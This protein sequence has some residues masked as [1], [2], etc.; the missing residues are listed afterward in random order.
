MTQF[1]RRQ[2]MLGTGAALVLPRAAMARTWD[3]I[4][5]KSGRAGTVDSVAKALAVAKA[6][7]GRCR[8]KVERGLYREKLRIDVPDAELQGVGPD[9]IISFGAAAGLLNPNGKKWGTGGSATLTVTAPGVILSRM[10]IRNDFDYLSDRITGASG[11]AQ[12][13]ALSLARGHDRSMVRDCVIEGYQDSLYVQEGGRAWFRGCKISGNVDFIFGG[14]TALFDRCEIGSRFV[15]GAEIQGYISA[16]STPIDQ[17]IGFVFDRCRLTREAGLPRNSVY[18]GR[19]WRA[20][21]NMRLTG[22]SVF[23]NCWMDDHIKAEGWSSMGYTNPSGVR[24]QLTPAEARLS[25]F[26]SRGPGAGSASPTRRLLSP[27]QAQFFDPARLFGDWSPN[28]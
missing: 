26:G 20:G 2:L 4:V 28:R 12:A 10:T 23:L 5:S 19:P 21:G 17:P 7:G 8:I 22:A 15:P 25:E 1:A 3:V 18:L 6:R 9:S 14:A 16:P 27:K 11:G 24:T 13:V